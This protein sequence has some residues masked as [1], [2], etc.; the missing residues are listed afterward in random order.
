M[1]RRAGAARRVGRQR[2]CSAGRPLGGGRVGEE[3]VAERAPRQGVVA[4]EAPSRAEAQGV[5]LPGQLELQPQPRG[6]R[7][8]DLQRARALA[9]A[10]G[11]LARRRPLGQV[12][13]EGAG[14]P[15][16]GPEQA[17]GG[18]GAQRAATLGA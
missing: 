16:A 8:L 5:L 2:A 13:L 17:R 4:R 14:P 15:S 7:R 3:L 12:E 6:V 10:Q 18:L 1:A 9:L 11:P